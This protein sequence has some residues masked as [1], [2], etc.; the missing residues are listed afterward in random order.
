MKY[1]LI[2]AL[3]TSTFQLLK[4]QPL[5]TVIKSQAIQMG[6]AM[7]VG[8]TKT[9]SK[10]MLPELMAAGG[11]GERAMQQMDSAINLFKQFGGQVSR[12]TYGQPAKIVKYKKE[13]QTYL[14]QTTELTSDIADVTFTS[15]IIA[16]SRD[17]GK[18][19]YFFDANMLQSTN[20]K[21]KLPALSPEIN[22]PPSAKPKITMKTD[23]PVKTNSNR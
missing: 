14:P 16:I 5:E 7:V 23:T 4:A 9:F 6:K 1:I 17:N 12:I 3:L 15:S 11:G 19:W 8:D 22:L 10:F 21:D 2:F 13:L 18:N 20:L